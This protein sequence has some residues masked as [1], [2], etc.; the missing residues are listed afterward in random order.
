MKL[1]WL[2]ASQVP[3][4]SMKVSIKTALA[5]FLAILRPVCN[6][7]QGPKMQGS[8]DSGPCR[9]AEITKI[10]RAVIESPSGECLHL[11]M[12]LVPSDVRNQTRVGHLQSKIIPFLWL[13][14]RL[15]FWTFSIL[16]NIKV[17]KITKLEI[18]N[19]YYQ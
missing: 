10:I 5:P 6:S 3:S 14:L 9:V 19:R 18:Y 12:L 1:G 2:C 7:M 17:T 8:N 4:S 11:A 13:Q 15:V 16:Y